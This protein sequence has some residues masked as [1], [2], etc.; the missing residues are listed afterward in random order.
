MPSARV[1][2]EKFQGIEDGYLELFCKLDRVSKIEIRFM[3]VP[4]EL[5]LQSERKSSD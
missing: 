2:E 4:L 3:D 1:S 5:L